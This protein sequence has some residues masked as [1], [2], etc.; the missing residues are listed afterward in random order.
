MKNKKFLIVYFI[1]I[2]LI[3][4][5]I[6]L[7][8]Q[9]VN[10]K[11]LLFIYDT[12]IERVETEIKSLS[13]RFDKN[14]AVIQE[15]FASIDQKS[16]KQFNKTLSI[17][18]TYDDI[19]VEQKKKTVDTTSQDTAISQI[20]NEAD[21]YYAQKNYAMAYKDF[22][23]VLSYQNDDMKTR[24]K[25]MKSLYYKN[26][27]DSSKYTEILEDIRILKVNG[28]FDD[29]VQEIERTIIAEREGINE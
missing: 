20:K 15:S 4:S 19:L 10:F 13:D 18:R 14:T 1:A 29:E 17:K 22:M 8:V 25:K 11:A 12:Q 9:I 7:S 26:R 21:H 16:D 3:A 5:N 23:K 27:T 2:L 6:F 28:Y 24:L